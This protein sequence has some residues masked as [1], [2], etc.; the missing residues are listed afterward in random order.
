MSVNRRSIGWGIA[1]GGLLALALWLGGVTWFTDAGIRRFEHQMRTAGGAADGDETWRNERFFVEPDSYYWLAY[2]RELR[3]TGGW[4]LRRTVADNAPYGREM[5]WSHLV[6]W[7]LM[8]TR[9]L[10]ETATGM[11]PA[12]ALELAGRMLL[13]G[14][15]LVFLGSVFILLGRR[16]G[17]LASGLAIGVLATANEFLWNFH[18]LRPDHNGFQ[19]AFAAG[20]WLCLALGGMGQVQRKENAM[21]PGDAPDSRTARRWFV[22]AGVLG[23]AALW[24]GATVF[25]FS[26][27]ATAAGA[28]FAR[29]SAQADDDP[30]GREWDPNLW[31]LWAVTGSLVGLGFYALEYAPAPCALRLEVNHPLYALCWLGTGECL[32][33]LFSWRNKGPRPGWKTMA[34]GLGGLLA[35]AVLPLLILFGPVA[36][37]WPRTEIMLRLHSHHI[38]EFRT[39]PE[40]SGGHWLSAWIQLSG[41]GA[42]A[43]FGAA[44]MLG[45]NRRIFRKRTALAALWAI[46]VFF[47]GLYFWQVRWAAF[48]LVASL[49]LAAFWLAALRETIS[50]TATGSGWLRLPTV[51]ATLL[52]VQILV[53]T[54]Q[55]CKPLLQLWRVETIDGLWFKALLQR[56]LMVQLRESG[57]GVRLRLMAPAEMVPAI[58]YFGVG[59]SVGSLYWENPAGLAATAAFFGDP[60]P[61]NRARKIAQ[62]RGITHALIDVGAADAL[63]F[64]QLATG[65]RSQEE[66]ALTVGGALAQSGS[67]VPAWLLPDEQLNPAANRTYEIA[68]ALAGG[69][70]PA[71]LPVQIYRLT[72]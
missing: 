11:D 26:L 65:R 56:N 72:P 14:T 2:A 46:S 33:T 12:Q 4:R 70:V 1:A 61:G 69:W 20:M 5:H 15:G 31:R 47:T 36:A 44:W 18:G 51:V 32:R 35:A 30:D 63:M 17:W 13:P 59:D 55:V 16:L 49:L 24:T 66:A 57:N 7:G 19:L 41:V 9:R 6:I 48:A 39:L 8:G 40:I 22:A 58:W 68:V 60:L 54:V 29:L 38:L 10:I 43:L 23:G 45:Q 71:K 34:F 52:A 27:C 64:H 67:P 50:A 21:R 62:E 42:L 53:G 28:A 25:L 3:E 37:Y